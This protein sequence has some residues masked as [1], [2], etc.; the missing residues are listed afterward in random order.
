M[1]RLGPRATPAGNA[2]GAGA[3]EQLPGA[4]AVIIVKSIAGTETLPAA[5]YEPQVIGCAGAGF[6]IAAFR[7][8][9]PGLSHMDFAVFGMIV[10]SAA[11]RSVKLK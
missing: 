6:A 5:G 3:R 8:I 4:P 1:G 11:G 2:G 10:A 7:F 9:I